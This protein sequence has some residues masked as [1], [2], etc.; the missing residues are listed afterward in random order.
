MNLCR[1]GIAVLIFLINTFLVILSLFLV[2]DS[3]P[4]NFSSFADWEDFD[5]LEKFGMY[6]CKTDLHNIKIY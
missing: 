5:F 4:L 1:F 6:I 3:R 2:C